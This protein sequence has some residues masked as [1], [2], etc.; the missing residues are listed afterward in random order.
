MVAPVAMLAFALAACG[1]DAAEG[2]RSE[3]GMLL[4]P[5]DGDE[6]Q[7][8][9]APSSAAP[10]GAGAGAAPA[11]GAAPPSG[12]HEEV[13]QV[14][15]AGKDGWTWYCTGALVSKNVVV[16]AAH[17]L[18]SELFLSW[19]VV[20]PSAAGKPRVK[21]RP[22]MYS[23]AWKDVAA[24]DLGIV[25]LDGAIELARYA[26]L[27][28]ASARV[29]AGER[30]DV[31]TIVRTAEKPEAPMAKTATLGV[32]STVK[33]GYAKGYGVPLYSHGGD[34]GAGMFLVENGQM[35]HEIIAVEREPD[36]ARKIDH[37]SRVDAAFIDWVARNT[38]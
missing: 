37:L 11:P 10:P 36:P 28:D 38:N 22:L 21:G 29:A 25:R 23:T 16:T 34:S 20:A 8:T 17:C 2:D 26:R 13:V 30:V 12:G 9:Q 6:A 31:A 27:N 5:A 7:T 3:Q 19:E 4:A 32:F 15:M 1:E 24:P 18:Q 33:Y 35:T 14:L